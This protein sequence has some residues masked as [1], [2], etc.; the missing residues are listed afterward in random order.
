M[1]NTQKTKTTEQ[2]QPHDDKATQETQVAEAN[3]VAPTIQFDGHTYKVLDGQPSPKALTY[4]A[5][6]SVDDENM[7][8]LLAIVEMLGA[9]QWDAWCKRHSSER[10]LPFWLELNKR[11]GGDEGN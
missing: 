9:E 3:G 6:W 11:V 1:S 5:R 10:I 4:I 8:M 7:A 2:D